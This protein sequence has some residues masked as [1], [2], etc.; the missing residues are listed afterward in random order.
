[1]PHPPEALSYKSQHSM[2]W[3]SIGQFFTQGLHHVL[4]GWDHL[5]FAS[6]LVLALT[7]FWEVFKVVGVF[8]IAHSITVTITALHGSRVIPPQFVEPAIAGSIIFV[9]LENIVRKE[10]ALST[11]RM[12]VA[13]LFGLVHGLGFGGAL[14]ESLSGKTGGPFRLGRRRLLS[15]SRNRTPLCGCSA[16]RNPQNRTRCRRGE[17]PPTRPPLGL[18]PHRAGRLLLPVCRHHQRRRRVNLSLVTRLQVL[19]TCND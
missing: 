3:T 10:S 6:A 5:L 16:F 11:R 13:F 2:D 4:N 19:S 8:T 7:G 12:I 15:R 1:M 9:A 17:L 18:G 14:T